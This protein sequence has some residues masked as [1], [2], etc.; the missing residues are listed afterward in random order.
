MGLILSIDQGTSSTKAC[1]F[2]ETGR[3]RGQGRIRV[4][5][6]TLADGSVVQDPAELVESCRLAAR[7]ALADAQVSASALAGIALANQGES[8]LLVDARS[9]P[10]TPVISWQDSNVGTVL[11]ESAVTENAAEI[12]RLTG[13]PLHPE[14]VA[15]R[16]AYR[17]REL[18]AA[19]AKA[20]L[21]TLDTW[22][23]N[24]LSGGPG[25][26]MIT[27]RATASRTMLISLG[28]DD[29]NE[30]LLGWFGVDRRVLPEIVPC[31]APGAMLSIDG[32]EVPLVASSFDMGLALLGHA[33]FERGDVKATFGTC[34]GVMSATGADEVHAAG[35][36]STIAYTRDGGRAMAL[37]GE[38]TAA[39]ALIEW[40]VSSGIADSAEDLDVLAAGASDSAGIVLV[41]GVYGLGA[42]HWE[43]DARAVFRGGASR[44]RRSALARATYD[45]IAWSIRD[46]CGSLGGAG[47]A[48]AKLRVDGGLT[49]SESLMQICADVCQVEISASAQPDATAWGGAALALLAAG[50]ILPADVRELADS[51]A[52][53]F[54]PGNPPTAAQ[55]EAWETAVQREI[56]AARSRRESAGRGC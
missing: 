40:A 37:D 35:L 44:P 23:V 45:A 52:R 20:R 55:V 42:P 50:A 14:F 36:L 34:L 25:R 26:P 11:S 16:L 8:F 18:G 10:L 24:Q 2:D 33:C 49:W 31:D 46:V 30:E 38:I 3:L 13:L 19:A 29:W 56:D 32:F 27:D 17:L 21:A 28:D 54:V 43:P 5:R 7:R 22:L 15:P 39:G 12:G 48:A 1:V 41:P 9:R 51:G 4:G 53:T 47:I 6:E